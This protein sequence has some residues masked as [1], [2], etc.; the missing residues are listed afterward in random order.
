MATVIITSMRVKPVA[1]RMM[2]PFIQRACY[3]AVDAV[4]DSGVCLEAVAAREALCKLLTAGDR[5][6]AADGYKISVVD[7]RGF[8][9]GGTGN[10]SRAG[11]H[12]ALARRAATHKREAAHEVHV[13]TV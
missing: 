4:V 6:S 12:L 10:A 11:S 1:L 7:A 8:F 5:E 9:K 13:L 3:E 2:P